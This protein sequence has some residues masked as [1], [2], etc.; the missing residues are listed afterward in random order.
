MK[1]NKCIHYCWF[2]KSEKPEIVNKCINS[3]RKIL[4][5]YEI[6]KR[7]IDRI[8]K[9]D[10]PNKDYNT[11]YIE[12]CRRFIKDSQDFAKY[13]GIGETFSSYDTTVCSNILKQFIEGVLNSIEVNY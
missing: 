5:D 12:A 8:H 10:V 7:K 4:S 9:Y 3:W 6:I 1:I 13:I 2:G 11:G